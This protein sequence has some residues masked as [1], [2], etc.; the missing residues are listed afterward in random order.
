M[1]EQARA[2]CPF[3]GVVEVDESYFGPTSTRGHGGHGSP[4]KTPVF[5]ILDRGGQMHCQGVNTRSKTTL[6]GIVEGHVSFSAEITTDGFRS[7]DCLVEAG[8]SRHRRINKYDDR[9]PAVF[10]GNGPHING[11]E[12]F[13]SYAKRRRQKFNG[14]RRPAF[15]TF[16]KETEFRFNT[17]EDD[18]YKILLNSCRM[19][20]P[21]H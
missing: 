8:F 10:S 11:I 16:L 19:K 9:N 17:R 14:L 4:R 20:P 7:C 12:R 5:G 18:L 13:W 1:A 3:R 2:D 15:P 6:Q 21:R